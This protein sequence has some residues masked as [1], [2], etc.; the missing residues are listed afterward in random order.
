MSKI[1]NLPWQA[2]VTAAGGDTDLWEINPADD[3]PVQIRMIRL[4][5]ISEVA[6]AGE[7][8]LR[9][10]VKRLLA[11][12]TSGNGTAGTAENP[13]ASNE[14]PGFTWE[15]NG[16]TVA[17]ATG[18]TET[19]DEIGWL[20]RQSPLEIWYPEDKYAPK[21]RQTSALIIR[22]ETTLADDMTFVGMVQVEEL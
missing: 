15:Y 20:N 6:D 9:V 1:W 5:Q 13:Q 17:T 14:S 7:E 3:R 10:T 18:T 22:L 2:T 19:L 11:T 8:G 21:A 4:G 12:V 16:T